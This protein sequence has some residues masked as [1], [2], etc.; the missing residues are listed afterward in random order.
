MV[1]RN[2]IADFKR[3]RCGYRIRERDKFGQRFYI[4]TA[5]NLD[6]IRRF[7]GFGHNDSTVVDLELFGHLYFG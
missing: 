1:G 7:S 6:F 4:R 3:K 5:A 2:I